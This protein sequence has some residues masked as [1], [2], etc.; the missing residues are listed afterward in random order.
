MEGRPLHAAATASLHG[1]EE[2]GGGVAF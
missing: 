2:P 1:T